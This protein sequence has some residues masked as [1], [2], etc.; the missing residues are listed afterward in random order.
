MTVF[1]TPLV[2]LDMVRSAWARYLSPQA[3]SSSKPERVRACSWACACVSACAAMSSFFRCTSQFFAAVHSG[4]F[5][6]P[7]GKTLLST[8]RPLII[9]RPSQQPS[10]LLSFVGIECL[11]HA[12]PAKPP[13]IPKSPATKGRGYAAHGA[14]VK[15]EGGCDMIQCQNRIRLVGCTIHSSNS[16]R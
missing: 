7:A 13:A 9:R 8:C 6:R 5:R 3:K 12:A 14:T 2:D 15:A 4:P 11:H 1:F 16:S 10:R